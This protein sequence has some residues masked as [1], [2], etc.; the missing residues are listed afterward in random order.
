[1]STVSQSQRRLVDVRQAR[2]IVESSI[3]SAYGARGRG[4]DDGR[5]RDGD[6]P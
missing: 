5:D 1:M 4:S 2:N 3:E 6:K